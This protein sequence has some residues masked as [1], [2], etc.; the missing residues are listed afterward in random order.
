MAFAGLDPKIHKS[1]TSVN[2]RSHITK[3][4]NKLIR[5]ALY[6]AA[7]SASISN[8]Q[9]IKLKERLLKVGKMK[10]VIQVAIAHKLLRQLFGVIKSKKKYQSNYLQKRI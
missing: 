5:K 3:K 8:E 6:M 1:G 10:R 4:G 9:C 2:E 7:L